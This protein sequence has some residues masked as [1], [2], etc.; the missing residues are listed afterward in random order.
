MFTFSTYLVI[1]CL[2]FVYILFTICFR[3]RNGHCVNA[4]NVC[5]GINHCSDTSDELD[6][7]PKDQFQCTSTK[8]C[9]AN[10]KTCDGT[11]DCQDGSD[12]TIPN[13]ENHYPL[14]Q[15]SQDLEITVGVLISFVFIGCIIGG[16]VLF[17]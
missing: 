6:C 4:T 15:N 2:Y 17:K 16:I 10:E 11:K 13:C 12:E 9:I 14:K 7:C 5:D 8:E 1:I 3:C